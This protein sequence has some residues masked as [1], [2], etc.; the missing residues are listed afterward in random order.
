[1]NSEIRKYNYMFVVFYFEYLRYFALHNRDNH[2][3]KL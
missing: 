1:M 2:L 3:Q